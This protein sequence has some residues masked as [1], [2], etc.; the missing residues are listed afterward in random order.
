MSNSSENYSQEPQ[1]LSLRLMLQIPGYQG[2]DPRTKR[3]RE[4]PCVLSWNNVLQLEHHARQGL[5]LKIQ[6]AF[7]SALRAS[8]TDSL[9]RTTSARNTLSIAADTLASYQATAREQRALKARNARLEKK[10][11]ST[12]PSKSSPSGT[13][14]ALT[15]QTPAPDLHKPMSAHPPKD[16]PAPF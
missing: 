8:A 6:N 3:V 11:K 12:P 7:L 9:T 10:R 16:D 14:E 15:P 5:K 13:L 2:K 4:M 1:N